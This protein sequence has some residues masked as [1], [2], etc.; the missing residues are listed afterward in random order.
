MKAVSTAPTLVVWVAS[1]ADPDFRVAENLILP[2]SVPVSPESER[3]V[4]TQSLKPMSIADMGEMIT[5][6]K[7]VPA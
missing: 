4:T 3:A 2:P 6:D 1:T 5:N 7:R